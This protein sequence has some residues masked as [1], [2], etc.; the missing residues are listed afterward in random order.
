[1]DALLTFFAS[2][3]IPKSILTNKRFEILIQSANSLLTILTMKTLNTR[4]WYMFNSTLAIIRS[5]KSKAELVT[6]M[7]NEWF[8]VRDEAVIGFIVCTIDENWN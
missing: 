5:D 4:M 6:M 7:I 8:T 1:M 2:P 3:D